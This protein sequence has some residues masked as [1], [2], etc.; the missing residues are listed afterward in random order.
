MIE[1]D[2]IPYEDDKFYSPCTSV[3]STA[4]EPTIR[5]PTKSAYCC[6]SVIYVLAREGAHCL[7]WWDE[8]KPCCRCGNDSSEGDD[9]Y[10]E[11][12]PKSPD[13]LHN[14]GTPDMMAD[15]FVPLRIKAQMA[16][17]GLAPNQLQRWWCPDTN[18]DM[19]PLDEP[20]VRAAIRHLLNDIWRA[21]EHIDGSQHGG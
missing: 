4:T 5:E 6:E 12:C 1:C 13:P 16:R 21:P 17:D 10:V 7:H 8:D 3:L 18:R 9:G 20:E 2:E 19:D 14:D 11:V 15:L